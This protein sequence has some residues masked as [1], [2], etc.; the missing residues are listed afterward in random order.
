MARLGRARPNRPIIVRAH[1]VDTPDVRGTKPVIVTR[2]DR[3]FFRTKPVTVMRGREQAAVVATATPKPLV[4]SVPSRRHG[5]PNKVTIVRADTTFA[6][7]AIPAPIVVTNPGI[8]RGVPNEAL[9]VRAD[10]TFATEAI[11]APIVVTSSR[12][13]P[14]MAPIVIGNPV[15]EAA[16]VVGE[17]TPQPLVIIARRPQRTPGS[18][19]IIRNPAEGVPVPPSPGPDPDF[20]VYPP[21]IDW[22]TGQPF[23]DWAATAP[24]VDWRATI[25]EEC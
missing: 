6:T 18:T 5:R 11:A 22:G 16:P 17:V 2:T 13:R 8:R 23:T 25:V 19:I 15:Q 20:C 12:R 1:L 24:V 14:T 3:K 7:V 9:T 4:I 21:F 10:I